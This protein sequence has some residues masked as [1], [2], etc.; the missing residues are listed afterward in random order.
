MPTQAPTQAVKKDN[1]YTYS[2]TLT[3]DDD[4][5][6]ELIDGVIHMMAPPN[7]KHQAICREILTQLTVFLR[8]KPCKVYDALS[9]RLNAAGDDNTYLIPD[10]VVVCDR[11]K[12]DD[13]GCTGAPDMIV[14]VLSPSTAAR[15]KLIKFNKYLQSGVCEYWIVDP[16]THTISAYVLKNGEY[17]A[18]AYGGDDSPPVHVLDG[19]KIHLSEVF[20][21]E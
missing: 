18:R 6:Y 15:D 20:A 4:R 13:M 11:S 5:Q 1:H 16:E 9:V 2:D 19:C 14:E 7:R 8:G 3:W 17:M 12:L 21:E 10:I